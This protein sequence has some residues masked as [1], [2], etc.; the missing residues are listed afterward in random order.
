MRWPP[1]DAPRRHSRPVG[2]HR[3]RV[4]TRSTAVP[5]SRRVRE[6]IV[7]GVSLIRVRILR[8]FTSVCRTS[9]WL[10]VRAAS[11]CARGQSRNEDGADR[12]PVTSVSYSEFQKSWFRKSVHIIFSL[13]CFLQTWT[14]SVECQLQPKSKNF[15]EFRLFPPGVAP[16][17]PATVAQRQSVGL[18]VEL[19]RVRNSLVS[20]GF[21]FRQGN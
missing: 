13:K 9:S 1:G 11:S 8:H 19:S 15:V 5:G 20:S 7:D 12:T 17:C 4:R 2:H 16:H 21:S 3:L 14:K 18:G 6:R 10:I